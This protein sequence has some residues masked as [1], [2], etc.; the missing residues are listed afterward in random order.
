MTTAYGDISPTQAAYSARQTL[1]RALPYLVLEQLGQLKPLPANNTK[2]IDFRRH[3][4]AESANVDSLGVAKGHTGFAVA[5]E[6]VTPPSIATTMDSVTVTLAQYIAITEW[7]DVIEDTHIDNVLAEYFGSLGELG[8]Q[9]VEFMRWEAIRTGTTFTYLAAG[10]AN[11]ASITAPFTIAQFRA[12]IRTL[13]ANHAKVISNVVKSDARWGTQAIE[14]AFAM[15]MHTDMEGTARKVLGSAF[16]PVADYGAGA[17]IL[18]G[19]FGNFENIRLI[20]SDLIGKRAGAGTT[21][22]AA[23]NLYSDNGVNVNLYDMIVMGADAWGSIALKGEHAVTPML[24]KAKPSDSDPAAQRN[25][26]SIKMMQAAKVLQPAH[27][28]KI[29]TGSY[30]DAQLG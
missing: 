22:G 12:A 4:L 2:T 1:D 29:V 3:R 23:P 14:P 7:T 27:M 21:V 26:A 16:T 17:T 18:K 15:V 9:I 30:S 6:G 24:V 13:R 10:V 28:V 19:E 5:T 8:G 20:S 25:K 11:E